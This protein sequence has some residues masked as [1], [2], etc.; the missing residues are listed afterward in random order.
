[1]DF[2]H[3]QILSS[4]HAH[5]C[6]DHRQIPTWAVTFPP[7]HHFE[8]NSLKKWALLYDEKQWLFEGGNHVW[9]YPGECLCVTASSY[10]SE[11][12]AGEEWGSQWHEQEGNREDARNVG[13]FLAPCKFLRL[14]SRVIQNMLEATSE[15][16]LPGKEGL[17][18]KVPGR[19]MISWAGSCLVVL[20]VVPSWPVGEAQGTGLSFLKKAGCQWPCLS[21][22]TR[23]GPGFQQR[24]EMPLLRF[25]NRE[26]GHI[27]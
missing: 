15:E 5:P 8:N 26:A 7:L 14:Q 1:M 19:L 23:T 11:G 17:V 4:C 16:I 9:H 25:H 12:L 22:H 27:L 13:S 20:V 6:S 10:N 3:V 18:G 21:F 24:T 2:I